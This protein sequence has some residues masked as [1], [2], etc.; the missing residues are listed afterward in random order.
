MQTISFLEFGLSIKQ[1]KD[2][3]SL[4]FRL[5]ADLNQIICDDV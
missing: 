1:L 3:L 2:Q 4:I 5:E